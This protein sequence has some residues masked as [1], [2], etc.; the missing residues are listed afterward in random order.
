MSCYSLPMRVALYVGLLVA[1]SAQLGAVTFVLS[2]D[3]DPAC[4]AGYVCIINNSFTFSV[5]ATGGGYIKVINSEL[6]NITSLDFDVQY[7]SPTCPGFAGGIEATVDPTFTNMFGSDS[8]T[9]TQNTACSSS[10]PGA[11][12]FLL[13]LTFGP[14][15]PPGFIFNISLNDDASTTVDGA[16]GWVPNST[17]TAVAGTASPAPEPGSV[18]IAASGLILLFWKRRYWTSFWNSASVASIFKSGSPAASLRE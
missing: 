15:V 7:E 12:D 11:A 5:D 14:G 4:T 17:S 18:A 6:L 16:G 3:Q 8:L 10:K 2:G 13:D 1:F 9:F